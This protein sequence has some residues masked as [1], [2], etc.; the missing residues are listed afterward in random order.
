M[1]VHPQAIVHKVPAHIPPAHAAAFLPISNGFEWAYEYGQVGIGDAILIQGPGQQGLACVIA[2]KA[3]GASRIIVS[4]LAR[5]ARRL[6]VARH[7]GATHTINVDEED[8]V[9]K[10]MDYTGGDGVDVAVDVTGGGH[11]TVAAAIAVAGT[12]CN[13]VLAAA[14]EEMI[15]VS[16]FGRRKIVMKQANG[17]S[18]KSVELAIDFLASGKLPMD[19][20]ATH[21]FPM[22]QA[23]EAIDAV[24]G[25]GA[26]GAIHVSIIPD[27]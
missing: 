7:L 3:A 4:G 14:G 17:H 22:T 8:L 13:I 9:R 27:F 20:I 19:E 1:Y 25:R 26:P 2:A 6:E 12:R 5:D 15:D 10:V 18:F 21:T 23:L 16:S 24:S 11:G